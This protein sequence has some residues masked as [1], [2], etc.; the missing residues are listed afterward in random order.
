MAFLE[1][2]DLCVSVENK[3]ILNGFSLTINTGE[4]HVIM[5]PNGSGKSTLANVLAGHPA[6]QVTQGSIYFKGK[7]LL[8]MSPDERANNGVFLAFQHPTELPGVSTALFLK[9]ALNAKRKYLGEKP[10]DAVQYMK[11][12]KTRSQ[13]LNV[14]DEMLKRPVNVGFSGGEKKKTETFQMAFLEPDFCI[15]DE[16][17]SGLDVDALKVVSDGINVLREPHRSFLMIT[18]FQRLL[19]YIEPD[20]IHIMVNGK[21]VKSGD[22]TLA[23]YV[24]DKGYEEFK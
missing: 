24:E 22:K 1:I 7:D 20:Y 15:L 14:T 4:V 5:G 8:Q 6:Y 9:T 13:A 17:D 12:L 3:S 16:M 21:I 19:T 18:H 23:A 11:R 10:I 2:K